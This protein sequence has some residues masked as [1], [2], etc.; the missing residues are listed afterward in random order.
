M[1]RSTPPKKSPPSP[2]QFAGKGSELP[3]SLAS[4]RDLIATPEVG[5]EQDQAGVDLGPR[6]AGLIAI[7]GRPNVGKSTLMNALVG[8]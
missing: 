5:S 3:D 6:H 1:P 4:L 2:R 8:Q 7:V